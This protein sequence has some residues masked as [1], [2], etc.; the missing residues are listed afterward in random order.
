MKIETKYNIG[1]KV[2]IVYEWSGEVAVYSDIIDGYTYSED[3]LSIWLKNSDVS[4]MKE[5][6]LILYD[7]LE[8]LAERIK[9][10]DKKTNEK[11]N[12]KSK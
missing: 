11:Q 1:E 10:I 2:W 4:D 5:E 9:E 8:Q 12:V 3:G 7:D 6:D